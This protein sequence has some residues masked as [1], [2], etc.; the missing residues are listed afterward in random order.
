MKSF[1]LDTSITMA[2]CFADEAS[3]KT[4]TLLDQMVSAIAYV[5]SLWVLE[6]GNVLIGAERKNRISYSDVTEF[7]A[8]LEQINIRIDNENSIQNGQKITALAKSYHLTTYD[9]AY[10]ELSMRLGVPLA[11]K[12]AALMKIA[13]RVGV[14]IL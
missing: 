3:T 12:D 9:A 2:W 4:D 13:K 14:S 11:T 8:L 5:P 6:V 1:V 7:F 10:L